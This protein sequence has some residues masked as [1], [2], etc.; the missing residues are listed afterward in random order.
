[1]PC[2]PLPPI[3]TFDLICQNRARTRAGYQHLEGIILDLGRHG[4]TDH[5]TRLGVIGGGTQH[6]RG[7][8]P[9]LFMSG[10][11]IEAEPH[12]IPSIGHIGPGITR[13]LCQQVRRNRSRHVD[14]YD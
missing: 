4:T 1:M 7:S 11:W 5:Q 9:R 14:S 6:Y 8:M 3:D 12:Y 2:P 13:P 10:L